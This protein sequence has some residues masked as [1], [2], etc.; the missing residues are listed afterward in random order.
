MLMDG[1]LPD[2]LFNNAFWLLSNGQGCPFEA[3]AWFKADGRELKAVQAM[4]DTPHR[5]RQMNS[6]PPSGTPR[7]SGEAKPIYHYILCPVWEWG[8]SERYWRLLINYVK[9]FK[10]VCGF[11]V[12]EAALASYV[13]IVGR[14]PGVSQA[15]E[16]ELRG[17][18]CLVERVAGDDAA[19]TQSIF[20]E[21]T[22]QGR[23][24]LTF[25]SQ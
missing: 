4:K 23:R 14:P 6:E 10:P 3:N 25:T 18:G 17:R 9:A 19:G 15:V 12:D 11:S 13:T 8:V 2:Y 21:L 5:P 24:F 20:D 16:E 7:P 22:R 1:L